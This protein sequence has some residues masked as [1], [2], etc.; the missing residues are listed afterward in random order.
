[1]FCNWHHSID[2]CFVYFGTKFF[3]CS[4]VYRLCI[5]HRPVAVVFKTRYLFYKKSQVMIKRKVGTYFHWIKNLFLYSILLYSGWFFNF[6]RIDIDRH[7]VPQTLNDKTAKKA[8][9]SFKNKGILE[10]IYY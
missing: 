3:H 10:Y 8:T 9:I 5:Y 1:M 6:T 4:C 2:L 7:L